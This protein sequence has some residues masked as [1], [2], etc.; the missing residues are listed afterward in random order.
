MKL[1]AVKGSTTNAFF[2]TRDDGSE[3]SW[4]WP[5]ENGM[6]PHDLCHFAMETAFGLKYGVYGLMA[7]GVNWKEY[8]GPAALQRADAFVR[9]KT[10][11]PDARE[12]LLAESL[13]NS[14]REW[15]TPPAG[16]EMEKFE[17]GMKNFRELEARWKNLKDKEWIDL[18]WSVM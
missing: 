10:G 14:V 2:V 15:Q 11:Q 17:Q 8:D 16:I 7:K 1:R 18:E 4:T 3:I 13:A 12:L 9:E 6:L 5:D